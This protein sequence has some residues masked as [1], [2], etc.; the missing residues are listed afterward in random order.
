MQGQGA[1]IGAILRLWGTF[2]EDGVEGRQARAQ[3][4]ALCPKRRLEASRG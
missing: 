1:P 3:L 4:R 2:P